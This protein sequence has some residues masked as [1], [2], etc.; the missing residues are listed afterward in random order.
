MKKFKLKKKVTNLIKDKTNFSTK[1]SLRASVWS[2]IRYSTN[3]R[4]IFSIK[5]GS[6]IPVFRL[7]RN[8]LLESLTK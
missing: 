6:L 8:N 3:N 5:T 7:I 2:L 4:V 1:N